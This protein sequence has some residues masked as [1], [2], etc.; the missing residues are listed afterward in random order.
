[1]DYTVSLSYNNERL[2][3]FVRYKNRSTDIYKCVYSGERLTRIDVTGED[4]GAYSF[5]YDGEGN[6]SKI[7]WKDGYFVFNLTWA[8]GNVVN[9]EVVGEGNHIYQYDGKKCPFDDAFALWKML[10]EWDM[11]YLSTNNLVRKQWNSLY[12]GVS[13]RNYTYTY[14]GDYPLTSTYSDDGGSGNIYY[15]YVN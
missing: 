12:G 6:I 4:E 15:E 7:V 3:E 9:E 2:S 1:M 10:E 14:D 11:F 13:V 5:M 8:A